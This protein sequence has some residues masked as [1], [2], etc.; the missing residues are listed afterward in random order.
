M[1]RPVLFEVSNYKIFKLDEEL[2]LC[3]TDK[4]NIGKIS[5]DIHIQNKLYKAM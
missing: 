3:T 1:K 5:V 2:R 4:F